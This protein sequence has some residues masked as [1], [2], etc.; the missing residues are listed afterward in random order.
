[1]KDSLF[2]VALKVLFHPVEINV[3]VRKE[4]TG[5]RPTT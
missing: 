2:Q 3:I 1:M 5:W 4:E